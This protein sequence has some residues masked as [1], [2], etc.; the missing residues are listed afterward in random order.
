MKTT[1]DMEPLRFEI[2]QVAGWDVIVKSGLEYDKGVL[3]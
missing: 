3:H 2:V 1:S